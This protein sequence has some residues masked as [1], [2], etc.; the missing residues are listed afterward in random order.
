MR[1][2]LVTSSYG[3]GL[4]EVERHVRALAT[5]LTAHGSHVEILAQDLSRRLPSISEFDGFVTRR[6]TATFGKAQ[7]GVAPG[8]WDHLRRAAAS[9][10]VVHVHGAHAALALASLRARPQGVVFTPHVPVSRLIRRHRGSLIRAL[11]AHKTRILCAAET[12]MAVLARKF[13][14]AEEQVGVVMPGVN[15]ATIRAAQP[16]AYPGE[17][18]LAAGPLER[19]QRV[20]RAIAALAALEP[21]FRLAVIGDGPVREKLL[22]HAADL[23]V[24]SRVQ[25]VDSVPESELYRWLRTASVVVALAE[26]SFSGLNVI[27]GLCGGGRVVASD[28]AVHREAASRV[29]SGGVTFVPTSGSPLDVANGILEACDL[30]TGDQSPEALDTWDDTV[31]QT[32]AIYA[33]AV[34]ETR[35]IAVLGS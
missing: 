29:K 3:S 18:V 25:F 14:W 28:I 30:T 6:F 7:F 23:R 32:L 21:A 11:L 33:E 17:V 34:R 20:D 15:V 24:S 10:D 2:A 19:Y 22:A 26:E 31:Q 35:P 4:A 5:G 16:L 8:L 27:E 12:E 9:Y 13:P 1:I